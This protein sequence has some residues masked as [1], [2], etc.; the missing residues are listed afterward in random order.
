MRIPKLALLL[1][2]PGLLATAPVLAPAGELEDRLAD[3]LRVVIPDAI[4]TSVKEGPVPGLYEVMMGATVLYMTEDGRYAVRGD[5][6]DLKSRK[7]LTEA[8]RTEA[9]ISALAK[10]SGQAIE[11]A[12][13]DGKTAH[14]IYVFTDIDCGYCRK[15]HQEV[16]QLNAAGITVKYLAFPRSGLEGESYE[17]AV[18]VWCSAD[19]KA[20]LTAAKQGQTPE[21]R[22]CD[23][24]V[25]AQYH[26]GE[27]V[28]VR[29]TP[30]VF[31]ENGRELGGYVPAAE[32]IRMFKSGDI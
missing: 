8:R 4:I 18:A 6:F 17:K 19:K 27:A 13:A 14:T 16:A 26:L 21:K 30:A 23:N 10:E 15:M 28:G 29:G 1:T 22:A 9:R 2:L 7:N 32:L 11:F 3:K 5:V 12:A 31:L 20:A 25:A 24:P